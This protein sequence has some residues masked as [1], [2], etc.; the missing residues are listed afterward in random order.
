MGTESWLETKSLTAHCDTH[1][2]CQL[3]NYDLVMPHGLTHLDLRW[4]CNL[5]QSPSHQMG[6]TK[7]QHFLYE[8]ALKII[9]MALCKTAEIPQIYH[10]PMISLMCTSFSSDW[11]LTHRGQVT[12]ICINKLGHCW[13]TL[14]FVL[15]WTNTDIQTLENKLQWDLYPNKKDYKIKIK[16]IWKC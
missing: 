3:T 1:R 5:S 8:I 11:M 14:C 16:G 13:F 15:I 7:P 9:S 4:I 6:S 2:R 12:H 10:K